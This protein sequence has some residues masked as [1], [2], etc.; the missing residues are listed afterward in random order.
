MKVCKSCGSEDV[1]SYTRSNGRVA[2]RCGVCGSQAT[3][4]EVDEEVV[5]QNVKLARQKQKL[6][7]TNRIER[8]SFREHSRKY[9]ALEELSMAINDTLDDFGIKIDCDIENDVQNKGSVGVIVVT[10][11]HFNEEVNLPHNKYN[12]EIASKRLKKLSNEAILLFK[13][14]GIRNILVAFTG[15]LMNSDRRLDEL[16]NQASNRAKATITAVEIL[17]SFLVDLASAFNRVSVISALGNESRADKEMTWSDNA[18][19]NNYD[20]MILAMVK[21]LTKDVE[22]IVFG[23]IDKVEVVVNLAG[24]NVLFLHDMS[25]ITSKQD[26]TQSAIG[27]YALQGVNISYI[28]GGHLHS[29]NISDISARSSSLVGSNSYNE[30]ALGLSGRAGQLLAVFGEDFHNVTMIDLQ[31]VDKINGYKF[32]DRGDVYHTKSAEKLNNGETVLKI[33]I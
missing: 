30:N 25:K 28:F 22:N 17:S 29:T 14:R 6:Q 1:K 20:Y 4:K 16:L 8:K 27:R 24:Q 2:Y 32:I 21:R 5:V 10:D 12:F 13:G 7:D 11:V 3:P 18:L 19:S 33:V 31:N 26:K 23:D 15:D 9:N